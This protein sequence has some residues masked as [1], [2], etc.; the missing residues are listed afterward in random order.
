MIIALNSKISRGKDTVAKII[1]YLVTQSKIDYDLPYTLHEYLGGKDIYNVNYVKEYKESI[2]ED[3]GWQNKKFAGKVKEIVCI[4]LG[5]TLQQLEDR[6]FKEKELGEEWRIWYLQYE[7]K[8]GTTVLNNIFSSKQEAENYSILLKDKSCTYYQIRSM[9]LTPRLLL[10]L[11][12]TECGRN[13]IH[14][15]IW[16]NALMNEYKPIPIKDLKEGNEVVMQQYDLPNWVI[17]DLRFPNELK[18]IKDRGGITIRI[19]RD[20]YLKSNDVHESETA[21]DNATFDYVIENNGTIE[22]LVEK[23]KQILIKENIL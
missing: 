19:N 7:T 21:L 10:Q 2:S 23:V 4:L 18:A 14:P 1:Q 17:S 15:N 12:G 8:I 20:S 3:S 22:E 11:I 13:I 9:L 5:C 16:V 6:E